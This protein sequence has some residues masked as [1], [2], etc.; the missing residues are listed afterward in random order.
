[1]KPIELVPTLETCRELEAAGFPQDT[2]WAWAEP[3]VQSEP[4]VCHA[5]IRHRVLPKGHVF[6]APTLAEV[7]AEL[8]WWF[9]NDGDDMDWQGIWKNELDEYVT[10]YRITRGD[11]SQQLEE[12]TKANDN[13]AEAAAQLYLALH[14]AGHLAAAPPVGGEG[15]DE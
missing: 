14:T 7:L 13:P 9:L 1:M 11:Q 2:V 3:P 15:D 8:P 5:D 12:L 4:T 10:A 6:V